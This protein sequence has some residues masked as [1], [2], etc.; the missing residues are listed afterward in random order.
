[1]ADERIRELLQLAGVPPSDKKAAAW[2][3]SAI[4]GLRRDDKS[5]VKRPLPADHNALL[6]EIKKSAKTLIQRLERLRQYPV[7]QHS[8]WRCKAFGPVYND[9]V[10]IREVLSTLETIVLAADMAKDRR[11][12]RRRETRKQQVVD[13]AFAFFVRFSPYQVSGTPTGRFAKFARSFYSAAIGVDPDEHS[14]LDRQIRQ[15]QT[16]LAI[17]LARPR[18]KSHEKST[19]SS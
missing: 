5:H 15:A 13:L 8:F 3:S 14:G 7:S 18:R 19:D 17:E 10:E 16:R 6:I 9:R 4:K 2:L 1:L 11:R 12:G